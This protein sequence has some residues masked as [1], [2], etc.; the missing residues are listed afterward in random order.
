LLMR[1]SRPPNSRWAR[2]ASFPAASSVRRSS[3]A[4]TALRPLARMVAATSSSAA[5]SRAVSRRSQPACAKAR[6]MPR[7]MP[8]LEPVTRAVFAG[9]FEVH[10]KSMRRRAVGVAFRRHDSAGGRESCPLSPC[11][12]R[13]ARGHARD[14][15]HARDRHHAFEHERV[16]GRR[17]RL[18]R[19]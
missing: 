9:E 17:A 3:A 12:G 11:R 10:G 19:P 7:P 16:R 4:T 18:R 1:M 13:R 14:R 2:S 6:A 8:R 5:S 15:D